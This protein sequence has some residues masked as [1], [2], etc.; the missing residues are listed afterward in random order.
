[1]S[2]TVPPQIPPALP[3]PKSPEAQKITAAAERIAEPST[4]RSRP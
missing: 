2:P 4:P 3:T 1:M